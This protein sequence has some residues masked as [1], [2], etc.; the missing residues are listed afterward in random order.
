MTLT[1]GAGDVVQLNSGGPNMLVAGRTVADLVVCVWA[2]GDARA[3]VR[4][5]A[6]EAA[7]LR[8]VLRAS[9]E[10]AA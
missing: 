10:Q 5:G 7:T 3:T 8:V 9:A 2:L 1:I 4:Q 6:F